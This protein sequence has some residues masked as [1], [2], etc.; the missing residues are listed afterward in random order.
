MNIPYVSTMGVPRGGG[1]LGDVCFGN[2]Q[3]FL[4]LGASKPGKFPVLPDRSPKRI[5]FPLIDF[6]DALQCCLL[7]QSPW[8][9][10]SGQGLVA[11][12]VP[13]REG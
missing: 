5:S 9:Y 1:L 4:I 10:R 8:H 12:G 13:I 2:L 6:F 7:F 11:V 3:D